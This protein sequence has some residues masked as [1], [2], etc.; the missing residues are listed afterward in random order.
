MSHVKEIKQKQELQAKLQLAMNSTSNHVA[1]WLKPLNTNQTSSS[2]NNDFMNLPIIS[3]GSGLSLST[4]SIDT[5]DINTIGEYIKSGKSVSSL[6]KKKKQSI[7]NPLNRVHK[8]DS[9]ALNAL[10]NKMKNSNRMKQSQGTIRKDTVKNTVNDSDSDEE[11]I[12]Q[13]SAPKKNSGLLIDSKIKK[14]K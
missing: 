9:K 12:I 1:N 14:R 5:S 10:R 7:T 2:S 4:E 6:N 8:T 11:E 3:G 13:K